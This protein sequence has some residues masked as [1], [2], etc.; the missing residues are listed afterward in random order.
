M[1]TPMSATQKLTRKIEWN[2]S[3]AMARIANAT[4]GPSTAPVVSSA[5]CTPNAVPSWSLGVDSEIIASRGAVRMPLPMRSRSTIAPIARHCGARRREQELGHRGD[6]VSGR[7]DVL[8]AAP[9]VADEAAGEPDERGRALVEAVDDPEG[10]RGEAAHVD[11][12]QREHRDHHLGGDVGEQARQPEQQDGPRG[13]A[14][15]EGARDSSRRCPRSSGGGVRDLVHARLTDD[16]AGNC[17]TAL[18]AN[19]FATAQR[20]ATLSTRP[21][22]EREIQHRLPV[23]P[24]VRGAAGR[25]RRGGAAACAA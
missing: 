1:P 11:E 12:V 6:A 14:A 20:A 13:R 18:I 2:A 24:A 3:G 22:R 10:Q 21:L 25:P 8:V 15:H 17:R 4:S 7:R 9:A 16:Q 23:G 19:C 5:R